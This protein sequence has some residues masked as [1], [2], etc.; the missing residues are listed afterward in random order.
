VLDTTR[1]ELVAMRENVEREIRE[2]RQQEISQHRR[3]LGELI[4]RLS[5]RMISESTDHAFQQASIEQFIAQLSAL[6]DQ[7]YYQ[8]AGET[9]EEAIL[10]QVVSA[11]ELAAE[12]QSQIDVQVQRLAGQPVEIVYQ[13]DPSLIAGATLRFGDVLIDGSIAGQLEHLRERYAS[14]LDQGI[15]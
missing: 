6:E 7:K 13:T 14:Q 15:A 3:S 11:H 10:A 8:A 9:E 5:A 2:A 4:T 1:Q 12:H